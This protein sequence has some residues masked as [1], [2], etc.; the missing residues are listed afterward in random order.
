MFLFGIGG[1]GIL[2]FSAAW[3]DNLYKLMYA[4][5][6]RLYE[7]GHFKD[8]AYVAMVPDLQK[9]YVT[10]TI[11]ISITV[12]TE[13][14]D[15]ETKHEIFKDCPDFLPIYAINPFE[16]RIHILSNPNS[17]IEVN[18]KPLRVFKDQL[19]RPET[20]FDENYI[21][22]LVHSPEK[23]PGVVEAVYHELIQ[24]PPFRSMA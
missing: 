14:D 22:T 19:C 10:Y 13:V 9:N 6:Y 8:P 5:T 18:R 21:L 3:D 1:S 12:K 4:F 17:E 16:S 15:V 20:R 7:P 2:R 23:V 11:R 24:M